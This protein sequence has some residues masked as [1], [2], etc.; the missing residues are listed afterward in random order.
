[1]LFYKFFLEKESF[2]KLKR[3]YLL[4]A[5]LFAI[6]IPFITFTEYVEVSPVTNSISQVSEISETTFTETLIETSWKD[7]L[8]NIL[9]TLYIVGLVIF[10][11]RFI[12]HLHQIYYKIKTNLKFKNKRFT[13]ILLIEN[14]IPHTF[15]KYIFLNKQKFENNLIPK[16]VLLHEQ[17]HAKQLHALDT[18]VVELFQVVF[19]FNPLI[20]FI[21][22]DIKLN[23]EF[24]ADQAVLQKG[25][26]TSTYQ[27]VLLAFS[28]S[29]SNRNALEPQLANA[30]NYSSIKKRLTI[31]KTQT[32]KSKT[33]L[34]SLLLLP[35]L[36][37][38]IYSF[39]STKKV[40]KGIFSK[41]SATN[42]TARSISIKVSNNGTYEV[43]D[44]KATKKTFVSIINQL[45]QDITPEIRNKIINIHVSSE[46]DISD[47]EVWFIYNSVID[48]GFHRIVTNNQEIIREKGNKPFAI[49]RTY[50]QEHLKAI[51]Q[52]TELQ[53][54]ASKE[55]IAEYNKLA[56][57]YNAQ[58]Q[59]K[60]V[61]KL[62]DIE[63]LEYLYSVMS[64]EQKANA[65]PFPNCPPPPPAPTATNPSHKTKIIETTTPK[66]ENNKNYSSP[67]KVKIKEV[68]SP[69]P[70]PITK[71]AT[72]KQIKEYKKVIK[73]YNKKEKPNTKTG[74][75]NVD[76]K[77]LYYTTNSVETK[78]YNRW[79]NLVDKNGKIISSV[80]TN[81]SDVISG[82]N[83]AKVY[84]DDKVISEFGTTK[85]NPK[86]IPSPPTPMSPLD[87][88]IHMAKKGALFY[89]EG[90][91]ISSDK[92]IEVLK[93]NKP[94]NIQTK[95]VNSKQAKVF[96]TKKP[97]VIKKKTSSTTPKIN[98]H[99][100]NITINGEDYFFSTK[101]GITSYFNKFG[102]PVDKNGKLLNSI[103]SKKNPTFYYNNK[104][105]TSNKANSLLKNKSI[106]M[107]SK[108]YKNG[109]Y[110]VILTDL[111][112]TYFQNPNNVNHNVNNNPNSVIDLTEVISKGATFFYNDQEISTEKAVQLTQNSYIKRVQTVEKKG[113]SP[114]VYFRN[115]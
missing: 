71:S 10:S 28:S 32:S 13:N 4:S 63:R 77:T 81:A 114:K 113:E 2:H 57:K 42:H 12:K 31:M 93:K 91:E 62:K 17:T 36:A 60:R 44:I 49:T 74:T 112:K 56:K 75:I 55:Q 24:L 100:G 115:N 64:K 70:P 3:V 67:K 109:E 73:D 8:P 59:D 50:T 33:R 20:Y 87:H 16:E 102:K 19:W 86:E 1:M 78:Y 69:P 52:K 45:H 30:I 35:L 108:V 9:W 72:A 82:Q 53:K 18:L 22:K 68:A 38:L 51:N 92:A 65:E 99:T 34:K 103:S 43:D 21:K 66:T 76:G 94:L 98:I 11:F 37:L 27:E 85:N 105:I 41:T 47:K 111:N 40:E 5:I 29:D 15:F 14:I 26:Q 46:T 83:I 104:Q 39:S 79:G 106:A 88:V 84:K 110:A 80:Q 48:Y 101:N 97:I 23:H 96:I 7:Y 89:L 6:S 90:K 25:I 58:P 61:I 54:S 107:S 95:N